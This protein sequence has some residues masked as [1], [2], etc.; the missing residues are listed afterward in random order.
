M[1]GTID[2][3]RGYISPTEA[4]NP[5][6][7]FK[8]RFFT[9]GEAD[10]PA[11]CEMKSEIGVPCDYRLMQDDGT[12]I[13]ARYK[14]DITNQIIEDADPVDDL[15]PI[16]FVVNN[17]GAKVFFS[18]QCNDTHEKVWKVKDGILGWHHDV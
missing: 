4:D 1:N 5:C 9:W 6:P 8:N 7:Y 14:Y 17:P 11:V 18:K 12:P 3:N 16:P 13:C 2:R 15:E 10:K